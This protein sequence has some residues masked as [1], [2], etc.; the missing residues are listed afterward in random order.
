MTERVKLD[1]GKAALRY[2]LNE[3]NE[4]WQ[5][6]LVQID[7]CWQLRRHKA[8]VLAADW[9]TACGYDDWV[10]HHGWDLGRVIQMMLENG[11][12]P[13]SLIQVEVKAVHAEWY[14]AQVERDMRR[15][16]WD[17]WTRE[18][19]Q[20]AVAEAEAERVEAR[21]QKR[22]MRKLIKER[23]RDPDGIYADAR[24]RAVMKQIEVATK[25]STR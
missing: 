9:I 20:A 14:A 25:L 16:Y 8:E 13:P 18:G 19:K 21:A 17:R 2:A 22:R 23:K 5:V 4:R 1:D 15:P 24:H 7:G 6:R 12:R 10:M 3:S 11:Y